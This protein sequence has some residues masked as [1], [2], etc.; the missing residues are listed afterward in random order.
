MLAVT[1]RQIPTI[2]CLV[3]TPSGCPVAVY[4]SRLYHSQAR[5][6]NR[7]GANIPRRIEIASRRMASRPAGSLFRCVLQRQ[8]LTTRSL[9]TR[10]LTTRSLT[11]R[12]PRQSSDS[13][14]LPSGGWGCV[15]LKHLK[16]LTC[17]FSQD[18]CHDVPGN[19]DCFP[20]SDGAASR[21]V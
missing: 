10:S 14:D 1:N 19:A 15:L 20:F 2:A 8:S 9:T 7:C 18:G 11:T 12:A 16:H 17:A 13:L 4:L 5:C 21:P 6:S 3:T